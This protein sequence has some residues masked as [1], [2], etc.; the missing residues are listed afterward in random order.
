M[1]FTPTSYEVKKFN[2]QEYLEKGTDPKPDL[3]KL[4]EPLCFH[5]KNK[6]TRCETKLVEII[7]VNPSKSCLYPMR[8]YVTC[9]EA[10][11]S[12]Y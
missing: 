6:L 8:D 2:V 11:V 9:V 7:K 12:F 4:C 5:W 1:S 10:C 3:M